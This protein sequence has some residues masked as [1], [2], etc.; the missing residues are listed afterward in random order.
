MYDLQCGVYFRPPFYLCL[1]FFFFF[2][3]R[4]E[5]GGI[6]RFVLLGG[7]WGGASFPLCVLYMFPS[8]AL[9][10]L[11]FQPI[12]GPEHSECPSWT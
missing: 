8:L 4:M 9:M 10:S 3:L 7:V 6:G 1:C 11:P 5:C 12:G 2:W